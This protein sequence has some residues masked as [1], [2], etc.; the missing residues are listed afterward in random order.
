MR[1]SDELLPSGATVIAADRLALLYPDMGSV[2]RVLA[3]ARVDGRRV[4][5]DGHAANTWWAAALEATRQ[6]RLAALVAVALEEYPG[7]PW[8]QALYG[9]V[10]ADKTEV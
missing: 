10:A 8:L 2:R 9:Q 1:D 5:I 4:A 7:D 3:L 6:G